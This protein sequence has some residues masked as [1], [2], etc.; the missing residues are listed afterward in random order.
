M[1]GGGIMKTKEIEPQLVE[2]LELLRS[3]KN[4]FDS[5]DYLNVLYSMNVIQVEDGDAEA[6]RQTNYAIGGWLFHN[7]IKYGYE[8]IGMSLSK[9]I[10][11]NLTSVANWKFVR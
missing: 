8:K 9:N 11:G 3:K 1:D 6:D 7:Q 5:H 2:A 4:E 10:H